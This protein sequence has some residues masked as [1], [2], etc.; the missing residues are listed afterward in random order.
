MAAKLLF[1]IR[2]KFVDQVNPELL[3]QILDK[4]LEDE[5]LNDQERNPIHKLMNSNDADAARSL[6]DVVRK[7]G[8]RASGMMID[9]IKNLDGNLYDELFP[10]STQGAQGPQGTQGAQAAPTPPS[11]FSDKLNTTTEAFWRQQ[12]MDDD[13]YRV[14]KANIK[15]RVALLITNIKFRNERDNREGADKDER[16]ME[17]LLSALGYEV[18]KYTDLTAKEIDE[19]LI[20]FSKH[21]KLTATDSVFVVIM[22]HGKRDFVLGVNYREDVCANEKPD[23]FPIDNICKHLACRALEDKPKVIIIQAC[24]GE[25]KGSLPVWDGV[26]QAAAD[27]FQSDSAS[28]S[29]G[30]NLEDDALRFV[31]QEKDFIFLLSCTPN[32]KS[33]R[34]PGDG[35]LLIQDIVQ[36]FITHAHEDHIEELFRKVSKQSKKFQSGEQMQI[37]TRDRCSLMKRFYLFPGI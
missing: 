13:V 6:I 21:P 9:H 12:Q 30:G 36:V 19:A 34:Y 1:K 11:E 10:Q 5:V 16:N 27:A 2:S 28:P 7:K 17:K 29:S 26:N 24:R 4:L 33:Y 37:A 31:N 25:D 18:V 15:N 8:D 35:S 14:E 32:A 22:S 3:K 20:K 23:E